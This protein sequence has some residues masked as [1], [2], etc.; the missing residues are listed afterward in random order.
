MPFDSEPRFTSNVRCTIPPVWLAK[1]N[2]E[3]ADTG[4]ETNRGRSCAVS[5]S[6]SPS[7]LRV[8]GRGPIFSTSSTSCTVYGGVSSSLS[9]LAAPAPCTGV[10]L[11]ARSTMPSHSPASASSTIASLP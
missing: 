5:S 8:S 3:S 10:P 4:T 7:K 2:C 1:S 6:N 9:D 11:T